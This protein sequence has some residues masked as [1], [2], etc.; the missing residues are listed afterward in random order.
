VNRRPETKPNPADAKA[1]A[2]AT[3]GKAAAA[4]AAPIS[5]WHVAALP[6]ATIVLLTLAFPPAGQFYLAWVALVPWLL[7][8]HQIGTNVRAFLV[9]WIAGALF[10]SANLW[11]IYNVSAP[12]MVALMLYCGFYWGVIALVLRRTKLLR[13]RPFL[14]VPAIAT[15][16]VAGDF[17]RA[18]L[19]TG[20]PWIFVGNTQ[21]PILPMCQIADT[22][23]AY[24]V[25]FWVVMINVWVT[26][27]IIHGKIRPL[28]RAVETLGA[29]LLITALYG[30]WRM[31][32]D[33][34]IPGPTVMVVQS[35]YPQSNKGEKG[36]SDEEL[37]AYHIHATEEAL[38]RLKLGTVD[39]VVWSETMMPALNRQAITE[40]TQTWPCQLGDVET[41]AR[42]VLSQLAADRRVGIL[43]GGRYF[44]RFVMTNRDGHSFPLPTD[45]RNSAY[46]FQPDGSF[47]D[48]P[49]SR[50]DKIH[51]VPFGEFIPFKGTWLYSLFLKMGPNYYA[52]Y[53]IQ[54]GSASDP[55]VFRLDT[56]AG[57]PR[58][59]FVTPICFEDLDSRLCAAM[60]RPGSDGQK[61]AA[62]IVNITNDGWFTASEN[63]DHLQSAIFRSIENRVPTARSVNTGIS[64]FIDSDGR[65]SDLLAERREGTSTMPLMLD[66]RISFYTRYGDV[67]AWLCL[68]ATAAMLLKTVGRRPVSIEVKNDAP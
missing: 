32:E 56:A 37:L 40:Y 25:T 6:M 13:A 59:K 31:S 63:A 10:F 51:L 35:N 4:V 3:E 1:S 29:L 41:T 50:Y 24:G 64:G 39:L 36:A 46:L 45:S 18:N 60:F 68:V 16:W 27:W 22:L 5:L 52:D 30:V 61:R 34:A 66:R 20:F 57:R 21:T 53:E 7:A 33:T 19:M 14:A 47:D 38:D 62:F 17:V 23:G 42:N 65:T 28:L 55:T 8:V 54:A 2:P 67:F 49:G 26:L 58:W 11:W 12:G 48:S 44:D 15:V 9:S 43:T